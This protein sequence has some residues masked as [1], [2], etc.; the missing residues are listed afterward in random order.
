MLVATD[1]GLL[2]IFIYLLSQFSSLLELCQT[3]IVII[4]SKDVRAASRSLGLRLC[5]SSRVWRTCRWP[6]FCALTGRW[7]GYH[8]NLSNPQTAVNLIYLTGI[9]FSP[10]PMRSSVSSRILVRFLNI[11]VSGLILTEKSNPIF[12]RPKI[13]NTNKNLQ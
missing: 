3:N 10:T 9:I 7:W 4:E 11:G 13:T 12:V 1:V 2:L 6:S 8:N 5:A